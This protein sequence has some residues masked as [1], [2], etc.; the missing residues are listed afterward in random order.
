[1][2]FSNITRKFDGKI[3]KLHSRQPSHYL[4]MRKAEG[5][6]MDEG[7]LARTT[8]EPRVGPKYWVWARK[9]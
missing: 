7:L 5:L 1:M 8:E 6:R 4:A 2:G 9:K 3:Y